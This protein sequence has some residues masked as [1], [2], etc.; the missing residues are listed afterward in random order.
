MKII[1]IDP[2]PKDSAYVIWDGK[3][4]EAAFIMANSALRN[5]LITIVNSRKCRLVLEKVE[6]FGMPVGE[7][8]F[9][10][11]FWSGIFV[12]AF[13]QKNLIGAQ[14]DRVSRRT[15]KLHICQNARAKD[16][17]IRQALIDRFGKPGTKK[18][19]GVTYGLKKDLWQAFAL[20]VTY[21]D[22]HINGTETWSTK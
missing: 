20:A 16:S 13:R 8:I 7:D 21:F 19:P 4:I 1:A 22:L 3:K 15:V 5:G 14:W 10:T 18:E 12:E 6:S 17:N 11:V 9:E 2:G